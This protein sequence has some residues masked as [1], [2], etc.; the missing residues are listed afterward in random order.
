MIRFRITSDISAIQQQVIQ[1]ANRAQAVLDEQILK[2]SNFYVPMDTQQLERS[3]I[4]NSK[5]GEG[6][7]IWNTPYARRIYYGEQYNFSKD[8]NPNARA[9][10]FEY[11]K[12]IH[13]A[14]WRELAKRAIEDNL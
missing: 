2:D 3:G 14:S 11:A 5:I 4:I 6:L 8:K 7:L 1:A 12:S 9:L 10:W 13:L